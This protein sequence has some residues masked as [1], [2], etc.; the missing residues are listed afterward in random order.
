ML[1]RIPRSLVTMGMRALGRLA[2]VDN[3]V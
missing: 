2:F 3:T 1:Y